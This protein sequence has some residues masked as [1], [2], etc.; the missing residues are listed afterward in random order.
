MSSASAPRPVSP[1]QQVRAR[2][3]RVRTQAATTATEV[4]GDLR[5]LA[6]SPVEQRIAPSGPP[7]SLRAWLHQVAQGLLQPLHAA[8]LLAGDRELLGE[9]LLPA[10]L[11]LGFCL[12]AGFLDALASDEPGFLA[13]ML[14]TG[15]RSFAVLAPVPSI[16]MA[17]H[18]GRL[19][20]QAHER[21]RLGACRPRQRPLIWSAILAGR[22]V[23]AVAVAIVPLSFAVHLLPWVGARVAQG[24]LLL[25][26]LHWI[27][28]EALNDG[29]VDAEAAGEPA[30]AGEPSDPPPEGWLPWF[31][32]PLHGLAELL[33]GPL[34][35]PLRFVV[36]RIRWLCSPWHR[37]MTLI[38][39]NLPAMLGFA[40][41]TAALLCTP[42]LN[43]VFRPITAVAA[44]RLVGHLRLG[45]PAPPAAAAPPPG[46]PPPTL[47][48]P[49]PH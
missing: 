34:G 23:V 14:K 7:G 33:P 20:A 29:C 40:A 25:W 36:R 24:L 48:A 27:V 10:L 46:P 21:L 12:G 6:G 3:R 19:C 4:L 8:R 39:Q 11:L 16:I 22:Q 35:A 43:L 41:T 47:T 15:L 30:P 1:S 5:V 42:V 49:G 17:N 38:E 32:W 28:V 13:T 2:Y 44:V 26:A 18:Y 9:A 45:H 37:E 31:L